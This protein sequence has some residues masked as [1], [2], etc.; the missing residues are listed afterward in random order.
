MLSPRYH[1]IA[2]NYLS[3]SVALVRLA[4]AV[5]CDGRKRTKQINYE[6]LQ[7]Q[8]AVGEHDGKLVA[9]AWTYT[10][11]AVHTDERVEK[12]GCKSCMTG[13]VEVCHEC[14]FHNPLT[15]VFG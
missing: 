1:F 12:R 9:A 11:P 7:K 14:L 4:R 8:F 6:V 10:K 2:D 5:E 3:A 15:C 13:L